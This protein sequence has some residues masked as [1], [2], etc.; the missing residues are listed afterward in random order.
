MEKRR[1][2]HRWA[3]GGRAGEREV[4]LCRDLLLNNE[5]LHFS[6]TQ[7]TDK[8]WQ[9]VDKQGM[10][11]KSSTRPGVAETSQIVDP[12]CFPVSTALL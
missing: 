9:L 7:Q 11:V 6:L 12:S 10:S 3:G 2:G 5:Q 1:E 4:Q 8:R